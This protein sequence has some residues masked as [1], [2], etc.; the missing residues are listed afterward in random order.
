MIILTVHPHIVVAIVRVRVERRI[1]EMMK[2]RQKHSEN[3]VQQ[4]QKL[5]GNTAEIL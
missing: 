1:M 4:R 2:N 5:L 3:N